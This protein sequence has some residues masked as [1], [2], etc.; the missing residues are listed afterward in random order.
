ME[1]KKQVAGKSSS[2]IIPTVK[3]LFVI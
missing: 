2:V 1:E 3:K